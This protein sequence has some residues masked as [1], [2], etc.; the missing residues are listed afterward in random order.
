MK[1]SL[2]MRENGPDMEIMC[3]LVLVRIQTSDSL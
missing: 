2:S 3:V 1:G